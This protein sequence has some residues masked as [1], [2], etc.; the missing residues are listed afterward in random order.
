MDASAL[1]KAISALENEISSL[2]RSVDS[3]EPLLWLS[4]A[5]VFVGIILEACSAVH[6]YRIGMSAWMRGTIRSPERPNRWLLVWEIFVIFL[7]AGGVAG[8]LAVGVVSANRNATLR[9][10]NRVLVRLVNQKAANAVASAGDANA[11]AGKANREAAQLRRDAEGLKKSAEDEKLARIKLAEAISW[12]TPDRAL[13]PQLA[14]R[15]QGSS[16]Q[17]YAFVSD[18]GEPERVSVLGWIGLL[19]STGKWAL[20]IA[21]VS[22]KPET[23]FLGTNIVLWVSPTAPNRVLDAAKALVPLLELGGLPAVVLRSG[24]GPQPDVSPPELI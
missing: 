4:T 6:E 12:R 21:P 20:E 9:D 13:M 14:P 2:E 22:F 11:E 15:L 8:E 23:T 3:L 5:I 1:D 7:V 19:L 10:K 16:G 17:R 18:P 24:W